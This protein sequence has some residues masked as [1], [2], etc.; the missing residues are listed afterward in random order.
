MK[1]FLLDEGVLL[2]SESDYFDCYNMVYDKKWGYHDEGQCYIK[3]KETAINDAINYVKEGVEKTYAVITSTIID[4]SADLDDC[5]VEDEN[6]DVNDIIFSVAKINGEIVFGFIDTPKK[7]LREYLIS[8]GIW[9]REV[10][11]LLSCFNDDVSEDD[12]CISSIFDSAFD[13]ASNYIDNVICTLD[14]HIEA[15]ID[16]TE[17]G[18]NIAESD[19]EY[20]LLSSSGRIIEFTI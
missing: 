7:E 12:L 16:Y 9:E 13:L 20:I 18:K 3:D 2:S 11:E 4:D 1:V 8:Q 10:D 19:D 6:Y 5:P 14:P 15:V 17:L